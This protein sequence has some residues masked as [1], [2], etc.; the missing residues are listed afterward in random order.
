[1]ENIPVIIKD[2]FE[3]TK[4]TALTLIENAEEIQAT[5]ID[6]SISFRY[7]SSTPKGILTNDERAQSICFITRYESL[8][9]VEEVNM[10]EDKGKYYLN[11]YDY[12]KHVLNEYRA[13][14]QNKMIQFTIKRFTIFVVKKW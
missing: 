11:N 8:P 12:I 1:V 7:Q 3:N 6:G 13:L 4:K 2:K 14:I 5:K 9:I 10:F